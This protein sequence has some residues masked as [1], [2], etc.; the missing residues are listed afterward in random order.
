LY[1]PNAYTTCRPGLFL[2]N[3]VSIAQEKAISPAFARHISIVWL[4]L[5]QEVI[6]I[7]LLLKA[8]NKIIGISHENHISMRTPIAPL[9]CPEIEYIMEINVRQQRADTTSLRRPIST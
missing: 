2:P 8:H 5:H 3:G 7:S 4:Y 1:I 6:G 9:Q